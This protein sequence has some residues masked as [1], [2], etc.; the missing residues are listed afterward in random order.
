MFSPSISSLQ[1]VGCDSEHP[2]ALGRH[3]PEPEGKFYALSGFFVV[4]KFFGLRSDASFSELLEH[5]KAFCEK[6]WQIALDGVVPQPLVEHYCFR[7]PYV[8][9]LLQDGLHLKEEQITV[10]SGDITWTLGA[11]LLE[12]GAFSPSP[13]SRYQGFPA[14]RG[15]LSWDAVIISVLVL[16]MMALFLFTLKYFLHCFP[17]GGWKSQSP[18]GPSR[19]SPSYFARLRLGKLETGVWNGESLQNLVTI[20]E[21]QDC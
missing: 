12:A 7:A 17:F 14:S 21:S 4:Y 11:A 8:V 2:C 18:M 10:G 13:A 20:S 1:S 5:G 9:S 3:Q 16:I 19:Y 15:T 6:P